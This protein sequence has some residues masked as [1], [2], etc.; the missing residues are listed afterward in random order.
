MSLTWLLSNV[1]ASL[2]LPPLSLILCGL[3]GL[4]L[5]RRYRRTGK[6]MSVLAVLLLLVLSTGAG[7]RLLVRPLELRALPLVAPAQ[8]HAQAIVILGGGRLRAAPEEDGRDMPS[9]QTLLRLRHGAQLQ[10]QTTL[11]IL[12]SGGAPDGGVESEAKLMARSL[13]QD[14]RV[15]VKWIE[16]ASDNTAQNAM[17]SAEQLKQAGI[18]HVLL[19]TDALHMNR[20]KMI[21][22]STGLNITPAPTGFISQKPLTVDA[23]IPTAGALKDSHYALHEWIGLLWYQL[24]YGDKF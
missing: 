6:S 10:R 4:L 24:R 9:L 5:A 22:R 11:P 18:T 7:A 23:Y 3:F 17:R 21:F 20:A 14:F 13:Q 12:V 1:L 19:V 2:L 16:D 15:P 8:S